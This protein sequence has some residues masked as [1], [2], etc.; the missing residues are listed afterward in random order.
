MRSWNEYMEYGIRRTKVAPSPWGFGA[1]C[2]RDFEILMGGA[3]MVKPDT[4]FCQGWPDLFHPDNDLYVKCQLDYKD[5]PQ[6]ID[7]VCCNWAGDHYRSMRERGWAFVE[8]YH[9]VD[10]TADHLADVFHYFESIA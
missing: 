4:T 6:I 9:D 8:K 10:R 1:S 5:L 7:D 3:V 2:Y